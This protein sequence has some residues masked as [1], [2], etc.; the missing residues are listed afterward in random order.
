MKWLTVLLLFLTLA[1]GVAAM[2]QILRAED[3][4][5]SEPAPFAKRRLLV[6]PRNADGTIDVVPFREDPVLWLRGM[7]QN[8]FKS[9]ST[10]LRAMG[11]GDP[12]HTA[13]TLMLL[14]FI[15]GVL[16]AAGPGHGKAVISAWLL[17]TEN[18]LRRGIIVA[19]ASSIIQAL[20]AVVLVCSLLLLLNGAGAMA[21][22]AAAFLESASFGLIALAGL[23]LLWGGVR[24][25]PI[26][27]GTAISPPQAEKAYTGHHFEVINPLPAD[28]VHG[29]DCGCGHA[30]VPTATDVAGDWSFRKA[31]SLS[32][33]V[34][35]RPCS[36]AILVLIFAHGM[37]LL[38]AG[39]AATFAMGF[40]TF[41]AV[42]FIAG[43]AVYAKKLAQRLFS[44]NDGHLAVLAT[45]LRIGGGLVI[46]ALGVL[47]FFGSIDGSLAGM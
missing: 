44:G 9:M 39:I 43:L 42:A 21:K 18:Q 37:G 25:L 15:Y 47:L 8:Y 45:V 33:A 12:S 30:H 13:S 28:H 46:T 6:Q 40:G 27:H 22:N 31:L 36:G 32:F 29:P 10:S 3:P 5:A 1:V 35:I 34:G 41:L 11:A 17:A 26:W 23:Y 19:F 16:H 14:S 24:S 2:P 20:T 4:V 7:Q 38:W